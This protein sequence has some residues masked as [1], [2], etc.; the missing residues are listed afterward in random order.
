[1]S[2]SNIAIEDGVDSTKS[3][4][5]HAAGSELSSTGEG[6]LPAIVGV[7]MI[8]RENRGNLGEWTCRRN[9]YR[10]TERAKIVPPATGL[11]RGRPD[12][13]LTLLSNFWRATTGGAKS[14]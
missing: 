8:H 7:S 14:T 3:L 10:R 4:S 6:A 9:G 12:E 1:M 5:D 2:V 11:L 13:R